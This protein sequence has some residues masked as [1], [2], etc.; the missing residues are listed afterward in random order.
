MAQVTTMDERPYLDE[1]SLER[2]LRERLDPDVIRDKTVPDL[3]NRF[4]PDFRSQALKI[5]VEYD[6]DQHYRQAAKILKDRERDVILSN[7]GYRVIRIP[8]FVQLTGPVIRLL[9]GSA[10]ADTRD[11]KSFPHGFIA[12]TVVFPADF[13]ELGVQRFLA[14]LTRFGC[15][16][17]DIRTSLAAAVERLGDW[18]LVYPPSLRDDPAFRG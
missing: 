3:P 6:G 15:I 18:Q 12:Q 2:F 14:D 10:I 5:I 1:S 11:F 9:F 8:Y 7:A 13:C 16:A 17:D 4:R